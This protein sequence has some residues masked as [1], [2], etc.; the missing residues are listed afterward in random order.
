MPILDG[1]EA[2]K[3]IHK[4]FPTVRIL[5]LT[6]FADDVYVRQCLEYGINGFLTKTMELDDIIRA[7]RTAYSNEVYHTKLLDNSLFKNYLVQKKKTSAN[8]LPDFS[9]E[10]IRILALLSEE[11][12][13]YEISCMLNLS[14]RSIEIKRD[15]M[16]EKANVK[17]IGGL[18]L[19]AFKRK[20]I[21]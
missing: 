7:M 9:D 18:L 14:K 11:K 13:T 2:L 3:V 20:L 5:I 17:T 1:I 8:L 10:E 6:G 15:R 4:N 16:R 12:N 21:L 19:Y